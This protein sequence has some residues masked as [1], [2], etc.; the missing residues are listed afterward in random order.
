M[1]RGRPIKSQIRQNIIEILNVMGR[2]Y[3]YEIH[4]IY[5]EIFPECTREVVYYHLK[6]GVQ[7][8]E[9]AI[10]EVKQE[11]GNYSWGGIVE[12]TYYKLGQNA[13]PAGDSRVKEFFDRRK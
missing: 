4:K 12:K 6:K 5:K 13:K 8:G 1:P 3:G 9:F 7:L 11:H 10:D 2:G